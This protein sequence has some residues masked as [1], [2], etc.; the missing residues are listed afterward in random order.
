MALT[1]QEVI[2]GYFWSFQ[3]ILEFNLTEFLSVH[4][5]Q[6]TKLLKE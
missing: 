2:Q 3:L 5:V 1:C 4:C 6:V